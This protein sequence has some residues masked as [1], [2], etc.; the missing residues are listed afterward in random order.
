MTSKME[1]NIKWCT[2]CN[3]P[4]IGEICNICGSS[5]RECARDLKPIFSSE[6]TLFEELLGVRLPPF[7][8]RYRNRVIS[9]GETF[10]TFKLDVINRRLIPLYYKKNVNCAED[11][12]FLEGIKRTIKANI[13]YLKNKEEETINFIK[14]AV[15]DC[16][17]T[18]VLFGGGKDSTVVAMLAKKALGNVPLLFVD[19]TLEFP[20]TYRFVEEFSRTYNFPLIKD[21]HGKYYRAKQSFFKLCKKLGPPSIYYRWCCHVFKEQPVRCFINDYLNDPTDAA[22][23]TGIRRGESRRR[24]NYLSIERGK[25]IVGQKL[26]Q[27]INNWS[28]LEVWLY[29]LWKGIK[30]NKLYELGHT[31]VGCWPCPC[32]PP[33]MDFMRQLTHAFLWTK[34]EKLLLSYAAENYRSREW[35]KKGLWRL[36]KPKRQKIFLNPLHVKKEDEKL[37]FEFLLPYRRDTFDWLKILGEMKVN[38]DKSFKLN[39]QQEFEMSGRVKESQVELVVKCNIEDYTRIKMLIEKVLFRSINC[40]QCGACIGSCFKGALHVTKKRVNITS[41]C[42]RCWLCL[43]NSCIVQDSEKMY[44]AKLDAFSLSPCEKGLPMNHVVF[45]NKEIGKKV[46]EALKAMGRDIEIHDEGRIVCVDAFISKKELD[47]VVL[48]QLVFLK[49][50]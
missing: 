24:S 10:L 27:P 11:M 20:E 21:A 13:E 47:H 44:V 15:Q 18:F 17:R 8:F 1:K 49:K 28:D 38:E 37:V 33:L 30:I 16:S 3:I 14:E 5:G 26:I 39:T 45:Y 19:T 31:R 46:A 43:K 7:A 42:D 12:D 50:T 6:R 41:K 9:E 25:K 48:E 23:L 22:F 40:I 2:N 35:V 36:R 29:I 32:T 34:F 4:I